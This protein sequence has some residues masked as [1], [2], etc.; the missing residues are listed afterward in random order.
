MTR[1]LLRAW[2][3][4][5]YGGLALLPFVSTLLVERGYSDAQ[6]A[7]WL[8]LTPIGLLLGGPIWAW[9]ADRSGQRVWILRGAAALAVVGAALLLWV[10]TP[11]GL[12]AGLFTLALASAPLGPLSDAMAVQ[13]LD[14]DVGAY[15]RVRSWG[16]FGFLV[17]ILVGGWASGWSSR[18]A[19]ALPMAALVARALLAWALPVPKGSI[20]LGVRPWIPRDRSALILLTALLLHGITLA[21]YDTLITLHFR[22][23]GVAPWA[24]GVA[25][26]LGVAAE[27]AV[28]A[29]G[30]A[31][32]RRFSASTLLWV[33]MAAGV[34]RW[35]LTAWAIHP[36]MVVVAQTL[37]G[38]HFA[39][40]WLAAVQIMHRLAPPG[41]ANQAQ[42]L[43]TATSFAA[44]Y[45]VA[46]G[47]NTALL[48][49][50]DTATV[51]WAMAGLSAIA[52]TVAAAR[53]TS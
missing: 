6:S 4:T 33:G 49:V 21:T 48:R 40:F 50:G 51:F 26:A 37:H 2:F 35:I 44:A 1:A 8:A 28:L 42:A 20:N 24:T 43:L 46:S 11:W 13:A 36:L 14:G 29:G 18:A 19:F 38:L 12:G 27:I 32:L 7:A 16:S 52:A 25:M 53:P 9:W 5:S 34:P 41:R 30:S 3:A 22:R 10:P 39:V 15:G 17:A 45:F 23:V 47:L 31:L